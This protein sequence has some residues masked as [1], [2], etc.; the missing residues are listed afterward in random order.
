MRFTCGIGI[1]L[2][3]IALL[4]PGNT[5]AQGVIDDEAKIFYRN[6]R[7]FSGNLFS[8]G[9]SIGMQYA[10][11]KNAFRS[12]LFGGDIGILRHP[13]EYKSQSP[14][15]TGW[16]TGFVFG[17][18]N[19]VISLRFGLGLHK[20]IFGKYDKG[21]IAIRYFFTSGVS[22]ALMKPVYYAKVVGFDY[23][24]LKVITEESLF[25]PDYMQSI[26]D[27]FD[28]KSFFT[29]ID[30]IKANP[31]VFVRAGLSFEYSIQDRII[32]ALEGG[33]QVEGFLAKVP[34]MASDDN[35]Q[36]FFSLFVSYRFGKVLDARY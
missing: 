25:D 23:K 29:G 21:G 2:F 28:K 3:I 8:S 5:M 20:E 11:R 6:E 30:E 1:C 13:K 10:K 16:G 35:Q 36:L 26:Y 17:K 32:N 31:G 15:S 27:I 22:V 19:E 18:L 14:Y 4:T 34:I 9:W 7:T 33:V 12:T 24:R